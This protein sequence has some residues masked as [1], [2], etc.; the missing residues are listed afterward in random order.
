MATPD[1]PWPIG[2]VDGAGLHYAQ[3]TY[4]TKETT[5]YDHD[6]LYV[7]RGGRTANFASIAI[8]DDGYATGSWY[9]HSD[10][11]LISAY[12]GWKLF[13]S[14]KYIFAIT[15]SNYYNDVTKYSLYK[16]NFPSGDPRQ[17]GG[18]VLVSSN[19]WNNVIGGGTTMNFGI[20][21]HLSNRVR[22]TEF[23]N[24]TYWLFADKNRLIVVVK[25]SDDGTYN[26]LYTG[27]FRPYCITN[28]ITRVPALMPINSG[29]STIY[30]EDS[31]IFS[32]G[33]KYMISDTVGGYI[34]VTGA[35]G[36]TRR[37]APSE[38]FTVQSIP[39]I[40]SITTTTTLINSYSPGS[41]VGED[42]IPIM[43]R[44]H[45]LE[46]AQT[47]DIV[48]KA[49]SYNFKDPTWQRY[50]LVPAVDSALSNITDGR[51]SGEIFVFGITLLVEND[52]YNGKEVRGQMIDVYACLSSLSSET[53]ISIGPNKFIVFNIEESGRT[54]QR[55]AIGPK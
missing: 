8:D 18:W 35:N 10:I 6:R 17:T 46:Y 29:T 21:D 19:A 31:S 15:E 42:T 25:N 22:V 53:E 37:V 32:V 30:V 14:G 49:D 40:N 55:I 48:N 33:K 1:L 24:N 39:D 27:M 51:R 54:T 38:I 47:F 34:S 23:A 2:K 50:K 3:A 20:H 7:L 11:P 26:Y 9:S 36:E 5:G 52:T 13:V 16:W 44:V 28:K 45:S 12:L 4:A 43:C 41:L